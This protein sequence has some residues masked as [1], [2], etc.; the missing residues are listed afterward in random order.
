MISSGVNL[1]LPGAD[2]D[3]AVEEKRVRW[4]SPPDCNSSSD[5]PFPGDTLKTI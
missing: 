4:Q 5:I 2:A 1:V 3:P